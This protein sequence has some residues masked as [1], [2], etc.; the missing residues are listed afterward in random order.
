MRFGRRRN[1]PEVGDELEATDSVPDEV[2][3]TPISHREEGP[4]DASEREIDED[5]DSY[6]DL[7]A[8]IVKGGE[9]FELQ[10]P[11]DPDTGETG[12]VVLVGEDSAVELR[13]FAAARSAGLWDEV[14]AEILGEVANLGGEVEEVDGPF[15]KELHIQV[16]VET[17]DGQQAVQ[18][19]R[20]VGIDGPRWLLRGTFMGRSALEPDAEGTLELAVRDVVVVRGTAPMAPREM[21]PVVLP[22]GAVRVEE[23]DDDERDV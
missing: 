14:R 16:P 23:S 19:S 1:D 6:I 2:A 7:G 9:D 4:W 15:G 12:A 5:D 3:E 21:I 17:P 22:A 8:M 13:V 10:I 11:T 18:P 20:I